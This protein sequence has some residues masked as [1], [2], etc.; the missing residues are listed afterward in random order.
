M[1]YSRRKSLSLLCNRSIGKGKSLLVIIL[2]PDG[3]RLFNI[4]E[5]AL[6]PLHWG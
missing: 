3:K 6:G 2:D 1:V 4:R 5:F